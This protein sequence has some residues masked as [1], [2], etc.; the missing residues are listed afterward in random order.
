M[1][2]CNLGKLKGERAVIKL[3]HE[4]AYSLKYKSRLPIM[5]VNNVLTAGIS[6]PTKAT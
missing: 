4:G 2:Y 3:S 1:D 5:T 6:N